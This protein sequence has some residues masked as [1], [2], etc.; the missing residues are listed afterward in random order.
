MD[1]N[2]SLGILP[3]LPP[4]P[5]VV[6]AAATQRPAATCNRPAGWATYTVQAGNTLFAIALAVGETL[7]ELRYVNCLED[8]D[9]IT[10]G[11]EIFVP[12]LP[13][14]PIATTVPSGLRFG[15]LQPIGCDDPSV[16]ITSPDQ[17]Q[18][19]SGVITMRGSATRDDFW[20]YKIEIRPDWAAIYNFYLDSEVPIANGV[21]GEINTAIF[22][23]GVHWLR[24][25]VVDERATI[26][27]G[28]TC[29]IPV[30]FE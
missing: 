19:L 15:L 5:T 27:D 2:E 30:I 12:R 28:A 17:L 10:A 11:D 9:N 21:L 6:P 18:R 3:T 4:T 20:Y 8:V 7:D 1:G 13:A 24:L 14:Q 25:S 22:D 23:K 16:Q 26:P 29:E